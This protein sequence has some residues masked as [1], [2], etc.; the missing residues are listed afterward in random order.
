MPNG[1]NPVPK[2]L[3]WAFPL[4]DGMEID[5]TKDVLAKDPNKCWNYDI[6]LHY[7][8]GV[9]LDGNSLRWQIIV[10]ALRMEEKYIYTGSS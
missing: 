2:A 6:G 9:V 3:V 7:G 8:I 5:P 1:K 4:V 10:Q